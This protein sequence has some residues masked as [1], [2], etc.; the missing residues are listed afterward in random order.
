M[1]SINLFRFNKHEYIS[2]EYWEETKEIIL[3]A[4]FPIEKR[5]EIYETIT[6]K[7]LKEMYNK[8]GSLIELIEKEV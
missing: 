5:N 7:D 8:I 1:E 4:D 3:D 2:I 6:L